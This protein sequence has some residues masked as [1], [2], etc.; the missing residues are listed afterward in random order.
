MKN[1]AKVLLAAFLVSSMVSCEG[2]GNL[3]SVEVPADLSVDMTI[4]TEAGTKDAGDVPIFEFE[5]ITPRDY[6]D[7]VDNE[8]RLD[9][10]TI[11]D[12]SLEINSV[13]LDGV[14]FRSGT[15][16]L[17]SRVVDEVLEEVEFESNSDWEI[18]NDGTYGFETLIGDFDAASSL[19]STLEPFDV[20]IDGMCSHAGVVVEATLYVGTI[21]TVSI[22]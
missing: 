21:I 8:E 10:V 18:V 11:T 1:I 22:F 13:N 20:T 7:V 15:K 16:I 6:Q 14:V 9:E 3:F 17:L 12:I 5:T 4:D 2:L 19:V